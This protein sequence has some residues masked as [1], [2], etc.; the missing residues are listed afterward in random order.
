MKNFFQLLLLHPCLNLKAQG[1]NNYQS[2]GLA[3]GKRIVQIAAGLHKNIQFQYLGSMFNNN[4][5][6]RSITFKLGI[7]ATFSTYCF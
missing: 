7:G 2:K 5:G 3:K 1:L 4:A 6:I